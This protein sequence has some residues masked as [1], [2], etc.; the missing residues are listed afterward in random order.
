MERRIKRKRK[1]EG[2]KEKG[3]RM[4]EEGKE[5]LTV[6]GFLTELGWFTKTGLHK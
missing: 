6:T 1:E 3:K 4:E 2:E 5:A